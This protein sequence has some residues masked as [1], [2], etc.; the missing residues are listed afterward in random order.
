[1]QNQVPSC[2]ADGGRDG[3]GDLGRDAGIW[4]G[5]GEV[6][7]DAGMDAGIQGWIKGWM[8]GSGDGYGGVGMDAGVDMGI[9]GWVQGYGDAG[10]DEGMDAGMNGGLWGHGDGG[11]G[12][13]GMD[14]G[15]WEHGDGC[16][17]VGMEAGMGTEVDV[18]MDAPDG[19]RDGCGGST[20]SAPHPWEASSLAQ[21]QALAWPRVEPWQPG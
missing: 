1:M 4:G 7:M 16:R 15:I 11:C 8:Q 14:V 21:R 2:W 13:L 5:C 9:W 12:D 6:E 18:G 10:M 17:N 3:C 20:T 19:C